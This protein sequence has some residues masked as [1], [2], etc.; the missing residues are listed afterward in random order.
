M[1]F[2][3]A[4]PDDLQCSICLGPAV[5][6]FVTE[7]CGHL[8]CR[9]CIMG[10]L[11][12]KKEC[13]VCRRRLTAEGIRKDVRAQRRISALRVQ[14]ENEERGCTWTGEFGERA[15]HMNQC[16]LGAI[17]CPFHAL[18]C[19]EVLFR[20]ALPQHM[21]IC[22]ITKRLAEGSLALQ[23]ELKVID[24]ENGNRKFVWAIENFESNRET[25]FSRVFRAHGVQWQLKVVP[26]GKAAPRV[27]LQPIGHQNR[28]KFTLTLFNTEPG[29]NKVARIEDPNIKG[30]GT[31]VAGFIPHG[32]RLQAFLVSGCITLKVDIDPPPFL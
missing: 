26:E 1:G 11:D 30:K 28:A 16:R 3:D 31:G 27:T 20:Y 6:A 17:T 18:G 2:V 29:K 15:R 4:I 24:R 25:L 22:A 8:Y 14:C 12:K 5:V 32:D 19:T 23:Q 9:D 7:E 21:S 13:P 10:A